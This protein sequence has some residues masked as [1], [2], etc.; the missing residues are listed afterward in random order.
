M[1]MLFWSLGSNHQIQTFIIDEN[2]EAR[3]PCYQ[4]VPVKTESAPLFFNLK[5]SK[6]HV[7]ELIVVMLNSIMNM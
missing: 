7:M 5:F 4:S 6:I 1:R 3:C 2:S